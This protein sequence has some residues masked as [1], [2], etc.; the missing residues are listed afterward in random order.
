MPIII[1]NDQPVKSKLER[2][3]IL[4]RQR[5]GIEI[6]KAEGKYKGKPKKDLDLNKF[7]SLCM[8]WRVG[9]RTAVSIMKHFSISSQTFYRR[10]KE[11]GL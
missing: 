8:E 6:A 5:E 10:V 11:M 7:K 2:E 9:E 3:N 1:S 4:R